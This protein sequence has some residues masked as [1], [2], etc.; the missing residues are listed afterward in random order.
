M[1]RKV[2]VEKSYPEYVYSEQEFKNLLGITE[3]N[4]VLQVSP[5]FSNGEIVITLSSNA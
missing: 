4:A 3:S 5:N 2:K 1:Q